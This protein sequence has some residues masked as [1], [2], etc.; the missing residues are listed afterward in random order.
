MEQIA[1][2]RFISS[3]TLLIALRQGHFYL[4]VQVEGNGHS[5]WRKYKTFMRPDRSKIVDVLPNYPSRS[6][7]SLLCK[8]GQVYFY[9]LREW[10]MT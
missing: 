5:Q 7:F 9:D 6:S 4:Y 8:N 3:K 2:A 1:V 10:L